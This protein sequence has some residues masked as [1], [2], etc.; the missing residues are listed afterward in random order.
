MTVMPQAAG[1]R[2]SNVVQDKLLI[3]FALQFAYPLTLR[4]ENKS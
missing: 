3:I 4:N 1:A 2:M